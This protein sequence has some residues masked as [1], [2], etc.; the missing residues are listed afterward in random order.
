MQTTLVPAQI[1]HYQHQGWLIVEDFLTPDELAKL[2]EAVDAGVDAMGGTKVSGD[3]ESISIS[4]V[5]L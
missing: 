2:N 1:E 4:F 5:E 3:V